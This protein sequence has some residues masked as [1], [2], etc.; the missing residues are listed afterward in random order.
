MKDVLTG[1]VLK[2]VNCNRQDY[3]NWRKRI[4]FSAERYDELTDVRE[5]IKYFP[6]LL[7]GFMTSLVH[8]GFEPSEAASRAEIY[9]VRYRNK[10]DFPKWLISYPGTEHEV[11][12]GDKG[13]ER[14]IA[15]AFEMQAAN[16]AVDW[17]DAIETSAN[18]NRKFTVARIVNLAEIGARIDQLFSRED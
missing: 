2:A 8:A 13:A 18:P 14:T 3:N 10:A 9:A 4:D 1:E 12:F 15:A 17:P 6:A 16:P 7:I 11:H 5:T